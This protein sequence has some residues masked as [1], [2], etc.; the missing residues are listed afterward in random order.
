MKQ[1]RKC[2]TVLAGIICYLSSLRAIGCTSIIKIITEI[3]FIMIL[4]CNNIGRV[5]SITC[6][7]E[8]INQC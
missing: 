7:S 2:H 5:L 6:I 3:V 1:V 4:K 8:D